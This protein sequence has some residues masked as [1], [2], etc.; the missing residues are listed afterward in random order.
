M[1]SVRRAWSWGVIAF[2]SSVPLLVAAC[3]DF[4]EASSGDA[5]D[6]AE[7]P[8]GP[9]TQNG[10]HDG[11]VT[12]D[13]A[14]SDAADATTDTSKPVARSRCIDPNHLFCA[15]FDGPSLLDNGAWPWTT[16]TRAAP[17]ELALDAAN[18]TAGNSSLL[19]SMFP[20]N[21]E[22]YF[23]YA[24]TETKLRVTMQLR[25]TPS[26]LVDNTVAGS[27]DV[28]MF[29]YRTQNLSTES[30]YVG[31]YASSLGVVGLKWGEEINN[32]S[33]PGQQVLSSTWESF[34]EIQLDLDLGNGTAK[35]SLDSD[36]PIG[37]YSVPKATSKAANLMVGLYQ[38][39]SAATFSANV[40]D[41]V[42]DKL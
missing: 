6:R 24:L 17:Q 11:G 25:V 40:D 13:G 16:S 39:T 36:K 19:V 38:P 42:V 9:D 22:S 3:N 29:K 34:H 2:A 27:V 41:V 35:V 23:Q 12:D 5:P 21:A 28:M 4:G 7:S 14:T 8:A 32:G 30:G 26:A 1:S 20:S 31:I 33:V 10:S 18:L 15:G 37:L